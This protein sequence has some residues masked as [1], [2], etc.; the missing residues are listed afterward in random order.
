MR[1]GLLFLLCVAGCVE[2][3]PPF[4]GGPVGPGTDP[5]VIVGGP[6]VTDAGMDGAVDG[7]EDGGEPLGAC[8]NE[9]DLEALD[10]SIDDGRDIARIC[11]WPNNDTLLLCL[12]LRPYDQCITECVADEIPDLSVECAACY[13]ALERC[14][15]QSFCQARCQFNGCT[16]QCLDCLNN[17]GCL[18]EYEECRGVPGDGCP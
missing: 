8:D 18:E 3:Q 10:A 17:A 7:G 16:T 11:G 6:P 13:G 4:P 1:W 2:E 9:S 14:G 12:S 15:L 5:G